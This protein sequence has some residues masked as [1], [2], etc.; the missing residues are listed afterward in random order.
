MEYQRVNRTDPERFF[1][2][3]RNSYSTAALSNGQ[4]AAWDIVTDKDGVNVTKPGGANRAATA[5]CAVQ[6]IAIGDYGLLQ[7]WGYKRDAR[8]LGGSGSITSKITAGSPLKFAT[9]GFAAQNFA[10]NSAQLKS[11]H[12][13]FPCAIAI[14]PYNTAAIATQAATSGQYEVLVRCL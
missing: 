13:K 3:V 5:G 1:M 4:W 7:V 9:S 10:R 12:G 11:I 6:A 8:C 2:V 14:E